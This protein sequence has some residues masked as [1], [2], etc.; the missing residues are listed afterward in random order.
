M[1]RLNNV[2]IAA[3]AMDKGQKE[4][5]DAQGFL[6]LDDLGKWH[7]TAAGSDFAAFAEL[8]EEILESVK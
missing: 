6:A 1:E 5:L 3:H 7:T 2:L 4:R 8:Q